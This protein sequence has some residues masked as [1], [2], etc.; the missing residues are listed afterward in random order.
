MKKLVVGAVVLCILIVALALARTLQDKGD[1][2]PAEAQKALDADSALVVLD[3]RTPEEYRSETGHLRGAV[4][5]PVQQLEE[6]LGELDTSRSRTILVY[7]R[8]GHR[9]KRAQGILDS[10]GFRT[11]NMTGGIVQW[12]AEQRPVVLEPKE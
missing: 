7:C 12:N 4:L 2:S 5:I 9:S 3:V 1:M 6:R 10:H 8:A 11:I